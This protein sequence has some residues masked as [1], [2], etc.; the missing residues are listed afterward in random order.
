ME[1]G[2]IVRPGTNLPRMGDYNRSVILDVIRRSTPGVSRA[3]LSDATA[4]SPQTITNITRRLLDEG[5]IVEAGRTSRGPGKPRTTLRL[6]AS[7]RYAVGVHLDPTVITVVLL[8]LAGTVQAHLHER[9]PSGSPDVIIQVLAAAINTL[10]HRSGVRRDRISGVGVAAPGPIDAARGTVIDPPKL[11]GWHR[12]PVRDALAEAVGLPVLLEKDTAAAVASEKW[13]R[14]DTRRGS[15]LFIYMGTGIGAGLL[16]GDEIVR[17]VSHNMGEI[18]HLIVDADGPPCGCGRRGCVDVVCS[19][20]AI[21][22]EAERRGMFGDDRVSDTA[23]A[24]DRRFTVLT[25]RGYGGDAAAVRLLESS[26][27]HLATAVSA[28]TNLLDID[29]VVFGGPFWSRIAPF[30]LPRMPELLRARSDVRAVHSVGVSEAVA[31][32]NVGAVG[33]ACAVL[34]SIYSPHAAT[35]HLGG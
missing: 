21:V 18:G 30:Y 3:E 2:G 9:T 27:S 33:A 7:R 8:D 34:D 23:G 28:I 13:M 6:D 10:I 20:R 22:E 11:P 4:L 1:T 24:V 5:L 35:L 31:G 12:V 32:E 25:Q 19:P 16:W 29:Q 26:A 14:D 15:F 17:G